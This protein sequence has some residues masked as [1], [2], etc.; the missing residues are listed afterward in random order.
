[1]MID[2]IAKRFLLTN[3]PLY[4]RRGI[5]MIVYKDRRKDDNWFGF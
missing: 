4:D 1:M 5:V 3:D 2:R